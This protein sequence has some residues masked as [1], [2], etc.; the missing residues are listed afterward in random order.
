MMGYILW[1]GGGIAARRNWGSCE[2]RAVAWGANRGDWAEGWGTAR[3]RRSWQ[4]VGACWHLILLMS[5]HS[6]LD[7][8]WKNNWNVYTY[9]VEHINAPRVVWLAKIQLLMLFCGAV[10]LY[11]ITKSKTFHGRGV[12]VKDHTSTKNKFC[13]HLY[14]LIWWT[15]HLLKFYFNKDYL[16]STILLH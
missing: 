9:T 6:I 16:T 8:L 11:S 5:M 15:F 2:S 4:E 13:Y 14:F 12:L 3:V 7:H 1:N 10:L